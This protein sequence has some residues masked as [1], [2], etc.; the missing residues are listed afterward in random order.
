M[1]DEPDPP[2][3][4]GSAMTFKLTTDQAIKRA[5][6]KSG[7]RLYWRNMFGQLMSGQVTS[8]DCGTRHGTLQNESGKHVISWD[9]LLIPDDEQS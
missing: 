5:A 1:N 2:A 6:E 3:T 8:I 4:P 9:N 7:V